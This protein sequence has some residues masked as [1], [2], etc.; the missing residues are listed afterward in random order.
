MSILINK[1]SRVII[2]GFTG[3]EAT[4]HSKEM[5]KYGTNIVGGVTPGKLGQYHLNKPVFN[6]VEHAIQETC[7][8][9]SVI[10]VPS[11]YAADAILE[12]F[13]AGIKLVICITEGIPIIDMIKV[14][15]II[16]FDKSF[17]LIG[18]NCPGIVSPQECKT[19][20]LP[21]FVFNK[22]GNVGIISRSGTL[23]YEV[24]DQVIKS[25]EGISTAVGIGGDSIIGTNM[26]DLLKLFLKD[27]STKLIIIVGEIGGNTEIK[28]SKW[29][30]EYIKLHP[31]YFKPVISFIAGKT[32]PKGK[33][34]GH[35][36]A[37]I[38]HS[39]E[40]VSFKIK[41]IKSCGILISKRIVDINFILKNIINKN[42][43]KNTK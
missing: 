17:T 16:K 6:T 26:V 35:A 10:F 9:V 18:P 30:N 14:K 37:I 33:K 22:K 4:F 28:A 20:I 36:G 2:Q 39:S 7:A 23:T 27:I 32:A 13:Y 38:N 29:F 41:A 42:Y 40:T 3:K 24:A 12:S 31:G 8:N 11:M 5:I 19:G 34:M 21:N 43:Y 1:K 15:S 25:G